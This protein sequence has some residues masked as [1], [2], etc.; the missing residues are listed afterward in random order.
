[1]KPPELPLQALTYVLETV[2]VDVLFVMFIA[3]VKMKPTIPASTE[4]DAIVP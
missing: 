4:F 2:P 3:D 1:M